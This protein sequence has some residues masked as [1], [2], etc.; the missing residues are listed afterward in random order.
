MNEKIKTL[1]KRLIFKT[2]QVVEKEV[3]GHQKEKQIEEIR[4]IMKR[5]PGLEVA[6]KLSILQKSLNSKTRKMKELAGEINMYQ[7]KVIIL[8]F[9]PIRWN[10]ISNASRKKFKKSEEN[11]MSKRRDNRSTNKTKSYSKWTDSYTIINMHLIHTQQN[12]P[13]KNK[14]S[15]AT[16]K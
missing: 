16:A 4:E 1:Q 7:A 14:F 15:Y 12:L 2:E 6:E 9:R 11:T 3:L 10:M 8:L 13:P 5:Q